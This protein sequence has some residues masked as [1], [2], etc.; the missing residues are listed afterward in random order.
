MPTSL[1]VRDLASGCS[2]VICS[3]VSIVNCLWKH[4][5]L[6]NRARDV[7]CLSFGRP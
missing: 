1:Y 2:A 4:A 3:D 5:D 7:F 6:T